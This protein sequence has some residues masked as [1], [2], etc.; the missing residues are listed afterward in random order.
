MAVLSPF[1]WQ[2]AARQGHGVWWLAAAALSLVVLLA[3]ARGA[4]LA[5]ALVLAGS[6]WI[7]FGGRKRLLLATI[8]LVL[9]ALALAWL[10]SARFGQRIERTAAVLSGDSEGLDVALSYRLPIWRAAGRMIAAHPPNGTGRSG[11]ARV[12]KGGV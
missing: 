1:V 6:V 10:G 11:E 8:A 9:A 2:W 4:W 7:E 12:G 3:G 5:L